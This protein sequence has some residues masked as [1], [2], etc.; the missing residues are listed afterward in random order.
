[1]T[2]ISLAD[3]LSR[4][5]VRRCDMNRLALT[6]IAAKLDAL[7]P[8]AVMARGYFAVYGNTGDIISGV[9]SVA[10]GDT[11]TLKTYNGKINT[12]VQSV[13]KEQI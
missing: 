1:M 11:L 6:G 7:G 4:A 5:A 2:V 3:K 10:K 9:D 12:V 13:D 8:L